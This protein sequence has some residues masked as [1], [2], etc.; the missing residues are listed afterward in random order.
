M[1]DDV[2]AEKQIEPDP[3]DGQPA[4]K[5]KRGFWK[6][7]K[8]SVLAP[9]V[10]EEELQKCLSRVR[11]QLPIPVFWLLGKTQ[12]GKTSL[13]RAL[14]GSTRAE[15]GNGFRPCTRTAQLYPFPSEEECFLQFLDTRGLGEVAYDPAE[16]MALLESQAHLLVVVVRAADHAQQSVL[17]PLKKIKKTHPQWPLIVVQTSLHEGYP[18][19][20]TPHVL[21]YAYD[22]TPFPP[23]VPADLARSLT[24]QRQW[25]VGFDA[26]F[27]PVDFTL[28]GDG[29]EPENYGLD[30]LWTAIEDAL[31]LG[32]RAMLQQEKEVRKSL[33]SVYFRAAHPHII[34]YSVAAGSAAVVP[35]PFVD[36]PII[37]AIQA[38]MFHTIASIYGQKLN[39][40][41]MAE[42]SSTLGLGALAR[43]GGG[44]LLKLIPGVG[45]AA[46]ALFAGAS[47]YAL[48]RTL[49]A[50]FSYAQHGDVPDPKALRKLYAEEYEEGRRRLASY[51]QRV[52]P[53][54]EQPS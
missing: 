31:P 40:K 24:A 8:Q 4:A 20:N 53:A 12:S 38:K 25:F 2:Q 30:T 15:I 48:G 10:S 41:R 17:E 11:Q 26:R 50:Y 19:L 33:R 3:A 44:E 32:L 47:T 22:E 23:S 51:L 6:A 16:D 7:L 18:S 36:V 21:P 37:L 43:L 9:K 45:S 27:V 13:I 5:K 28:P 35:I 39:S 46:A 49:C 52:E 29:F 34:S 1:S 42:I 14:T 54:R